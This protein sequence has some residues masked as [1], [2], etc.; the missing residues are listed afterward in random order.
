MNNLHQYLDEA[1]RMYYAGSPIISDEQF[2]YLAKSINYNKVGSL[3]ENEESHLFP[4]YSLQKYYEGESSRPLDSYPINEFSISPKLDGACISILYI[5]GKLVRALTR[6]DGK[7]GNIITDKILSRS[8]LAPKTIPYKDNPVQISGEIVAPKSIENSRN[9][10]AGALNL[11]DINEFK[12]R[13]VVFI[14]H[15][16][17]P[18]LNYT[19]DKDMKTLS[20]W[21]FSTIKDTELQHIFPCDGVVFRI[22]DNEEFIKLGNTSSFPRGAYALKDR[23]EYVESILL[24]VEWGVGKSGKVTPVAILN[25]VYI[26]D[27]LITKATLNNPGFIE[28][29]GL[30]IGDK[31]A[32]IKGGDIIP[33]ILHKIEG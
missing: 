13:A 19:Y 11:K 27:S 9:Y 25:P 16:I 1:A 22:N 7:K 17:N 26:G 28:A 21:G 29:L 18:V 30:E 5:D 6:G 10:S 4:L 2:D 32:V 23:A 3:A 15:S 24:D 14:A 31:V 8:D 33:K 12:T 20:N